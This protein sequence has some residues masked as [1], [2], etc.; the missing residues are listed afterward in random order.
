MKNRIVINTVVVVFFLSLGIVNAQD[1]KLSAPPQDQGLPYTRS[2]RTR[3]LEGIKGTTA[4]FVG[5]RYAYINGYK[6]RL[7]TKDILH[8]EA[9]LQNGKLFVPEAFAS[10]ITQKKFNPKPIPKDLI[11]IEDKWVYEV[12]RELDE[13]EPAIRSDFGYL[14]VEDVD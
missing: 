14:V 12:V 2:A 6:V 8:S 11:K 3:A 9:V 5:G 4:I 7:D 13:G 10:L 1:T